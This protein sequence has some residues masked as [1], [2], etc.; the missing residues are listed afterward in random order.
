MSNQRRFR[1]LRNLFPKILETQ[2]WSAT[3]LEEGGLNQIADQGQPNHRQVC[4]KTS[5]ILQALGTQTDA[6]TT[7]EELITL[8]EEAVLFLVRWLNNK[9]GLEDNSSTGG[10]GEGSISGDQ[11]D[12]HR[13]VLPRFATE[14]GI[15][16]PKVSSNNFC[17]NQRC[18]ASCSTTCSTASA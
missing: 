9:S 11:K 4:H 7:V 17:E 16:Q 5:E 1:G 18:L 8:G 15:I 10:E 3:P 6:P 14:Q 2:R 13:L 12:R